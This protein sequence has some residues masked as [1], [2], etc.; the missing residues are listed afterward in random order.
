MWP[1]RTA[2]P[3]E[4]FRNDL[5][6]HFAGFLRAARARGKPQGLRWVATE[7]TG[8]VVFGTEKTSGRRVALAGVRVRFEPVEGEDME[9]VAA[10]YEDRDATAL[11]WFDGNAWGSDG[12]VLFNLGPGDAAERL[13][14]EII[15]T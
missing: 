11:F 13:A 8:D 2:D 1:F 15:S 7:P 14:D 6:G 10:A 5:A 9:E 3:E 12:R 4:S